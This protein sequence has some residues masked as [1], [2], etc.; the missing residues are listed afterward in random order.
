[1]DIDLDVRSVQCRAAD[2]REGRLKNGGGTIEERGIPRW[3]VVTCD[4][5]SGPVDLVVTERDEQ[6]VRTF[7]VDYSRQ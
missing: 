6:L 2:K 7:F 5:S 4:T 3:M 1:V